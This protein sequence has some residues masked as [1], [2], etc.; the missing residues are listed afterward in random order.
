MPAI[1]LPENESR[2]LKEP[3]E[4]LLQSLLKPYPGGLMTA[5]PV[6]KLVNS[7]KNDGPEILRPVT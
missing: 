5:Y 2:W 3:D 6:S 1:L 4:S 7:P